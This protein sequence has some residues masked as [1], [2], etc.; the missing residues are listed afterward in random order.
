MMLYVPLTEYTEICGGGVFIDSD[1]YTHPS[2]SEYRAFCCN[3][4]LTIILL[5]TSA[6]ANN[7]SSQCQ[8]HFRPSS[9]TSAQHYTGLDLMYGVQWPL[10]RAQIYGILFSVP[11]VTVCS[12][13]S[14]NYLK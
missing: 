14:P 10:V 13:V 3:G 8:C 5:H 9:A 11:D 2:S 6:T 4:V 1:I 12:P 7:T